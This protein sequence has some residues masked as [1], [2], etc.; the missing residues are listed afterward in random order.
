MINSPIGK[1]MVQNISPHILQCLSQPSTS[2]STPQTA[3]VKRSL[4]LSE[5]PTKRFVS[6]TVK[7]TI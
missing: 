7:S 3:T 2:Q 6:G 4:F 1:I 5:L